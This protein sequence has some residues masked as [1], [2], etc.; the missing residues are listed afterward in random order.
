[1]VDVGEGSSCLCS[2]S[3]ATDVESDHHTLAG[4]NFSFRTMPGSH[5]DDVGVLL[6]NAL[7]RNCGTV[8]QQATPRT[9]DSSTAACK[10]AGMIGMDLQA[11][12]SMAVNNVERQA[13][14]ASHLIITDAVIAR[15]EDNCG[16]AKLRLATRTNMLY[17][18]QHNCWFT[19]GLMGSNRTIRSYVFGPDDIWQSTEMDIMSTKG[20]QALISLLVDWSLC[21]IDSIGLDPSI[22]YSVD[23]N[24]SD[25]YLKIDI[26][27]V[28]ESI[29]KVGHCTYYSKQCVGAAE[30]LT[31]RHA[32]Y[33]AM[34]TTPKS[35]DTPAFLLKD[36]WTTTSSSSAGDTHEILFLKALRDA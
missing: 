5:Y 19:W 15:R 20:C 2:L 11:C 7:R 14:P 24:V 22:R 1:M 6:Q 25:L 12:L 4:K 29:G 28:D 26:H 9:S 31:G 34:S 8:W 27:K 32:R 30:C 23:R 36:V 16:K 3:S 17:F 18:N 33:F 21:S 10:L 35:M 13:A